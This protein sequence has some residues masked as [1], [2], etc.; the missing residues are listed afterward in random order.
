MISLLFKGYRYLVHGGSDPHIEVCYLV[1]E[2]SLE[3]FHFSLHVS[4]V[5]LV[6]LIKN[7]CTCIINRLD[8]LLLDIQYL[9]SDC[10]FE[11]LQLTLMYYLSFHLEF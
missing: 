1:I 3:Q 4:E 7:P 6:N 5:A 9:L 11:V 10:D 2:E 8:R